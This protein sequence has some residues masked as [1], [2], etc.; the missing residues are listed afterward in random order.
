LT[1]SASIYAGEPAH[2]APRVAIRFLDNPARVELT[3]LPESVL[4]ALAAT[5]LDATRWTQILSVNVAVA[6]DASPPPMLGIHRVEDQRII[7][8]PRFAL[9]PGLAYRAMF[10]PAALPGG[11]YADLTRAE[12][13]IEIPAPHSAAP[14]KVAA[15]YP[16]GDELP[17]NLLKFYIHFT[18]PMSRGDSYRH[19]QILDDKG[20]EVPNA[21]LR[22]GEELWSPDGRRF[23]LLFDPGRIKRGLVPNL[24]NG[25][26]LRAGRKYTLLID[27][28]WRDAHGGHLAAELRKD[29][30]TTE[31]DETQP[32]PERWTIRSPR[33]GTRAPLRIEFDE[34]LDHALAIRMIAVRNASG[35]DVEGRARLADH[36]THW[37]FTPADA[38]RSG[39][40]SLVVAGTLE[41]RAGNSIGR[42]FEVANAGDE[43]GVTAV[44]QVVLSFEIAAP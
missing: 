9:R 6:A 20:R 43:V 32:D 41:D 26:P 1:I 24:E 14:A 29:F 39:R 23:T 16:S 31:L 7:F 44:E 4:G 22:L 42:P 15:V 27:A 25:S 8:T 12:V 36:E 40:H 5:Q 17:E 37:E 28:G 11:V 18:A 10:D 2:P 38:W 21:F 19:L 3:G 35:R 30:H 33:A 13:N 34:P